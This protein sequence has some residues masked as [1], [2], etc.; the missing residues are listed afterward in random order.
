MK[1]QSFSILIVAIAST[2]SAKECPAINSQ[3]KALIKSHNNSIR[4]VEYRPARSIIQNAGLELVLYTVEGACFEEKEMPGSCGNAHYQYVAGVLNGSA[5]KPF[6]VKSL[7]DF[8]AM[9]LT[10]DA[11]VIVLHGNYYAESDPRCCPSVP[12]TKKLKVVIDRL[13]LIA[14]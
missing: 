7:G 2:A 5:I 14:Q 1:K 10:L 13:E 12:A 11:D 4:G 9:K 6:E 8:S 3:L